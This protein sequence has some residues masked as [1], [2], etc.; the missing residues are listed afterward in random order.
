MLALAALVLEESVYSGRQMMPSTPS[1]HKVKDIKK[2][3]SDSTSAVFDYAKERGIPGAL[4]LLEINREERKATR[5]K[6]SD[7]IPTDTK[8][9]DCT[10]FF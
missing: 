5:K 10:V 9:V 8:A 1:Y 6:E 7:E 3:A 4:H 2:E